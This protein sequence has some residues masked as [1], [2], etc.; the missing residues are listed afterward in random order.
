MNPGQTNVQEDGRA[1]GKNLC[2]ED[3]SDDNFCS[4]RKDVLEN[5][6]IFGRN[7]SRQRRVLL[8]R[9]NQLELRV[10]LFKFAA[11]KFSMKVE[12][13]YSVFVR[14]LT[15]SGRDEKDI[16]AEENI[17][18]NKTVVSALQKSLRGGEIL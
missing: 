11:F 15:A 7:C 10:I 2:L 13:I 3:A 9:Y 4:E 16:E 18:Y 6:G 17:Q 1:Y 12:K 5:S 8:C 14:Q